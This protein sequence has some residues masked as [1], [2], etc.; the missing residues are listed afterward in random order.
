MKENVYERR[1]SRRRPLF[2][3]NI[4]RIYRSLVIV[5]FIVSIRIYG[6]LVIVSFILRTK[7]AHGL[8][9]GKYSVPAFEVGPL[10]SVNI[11]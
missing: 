4:I 1:F 11:N 7:L 10:N 6:S 8:L 2:L 5:S 9:S 3:F